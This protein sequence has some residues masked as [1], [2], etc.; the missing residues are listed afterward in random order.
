MLF[1]AFHRACGMHS[2][3]RNYKTKG[4]WGSGQFMIQPYIFGANPNQSWRI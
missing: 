4:K 2:G 1:R 3:I